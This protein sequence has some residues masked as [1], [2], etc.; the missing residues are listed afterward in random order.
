MEIIQAI[1]E[2]GGAPI[3]TINL[4]CVPR[5]GES[6]EIKGEAHP[7]RY[8][9]KELIYLDTTKVESSIVLVVGPYYR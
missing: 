7:E 6:V 3:A 4:P 9:I 1:V 5:I 2:Q 8:R